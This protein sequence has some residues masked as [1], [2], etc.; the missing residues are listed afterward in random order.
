LNGLFW[1][2]LD[3]ATNGWLSSRVD[4]VV[5][6]SVLSVRGRARTL[7]ADRRRLAIV[8]VVAAFALAG[9][10]LLV[11]SAPARSEPS[12]IPLPFGPG[13]AYEQRGDDPPRRPVPATPLHPRRS[14]TDP[15][16]DTARVVRPYDV[17]SD[18]LASVLLTEAEVAGTAHVQPVGRV[19][20][21]RNVLDIGADPRPCGTSTVAPRR[22]GDDGFAVWHMTGARAGSDT[23]F[24]SSATETVSP[25][26]AHAF[27]RQ[28]AAAV[29]SCHYRTVTQ[30][31]IDG[32]ETVRTSWQD[33]SGYRD[34][35][36]VR[37]ANL[38]FQVATT[39][40]AARHSDYADLLARRLLAKW[41]AVKIR[42]VPSPTPAAARPTAGP[43][44]RPAAPASTDPASGSEPQ[45]TGTPPYPPGCL[46]GM[47]GGANVPIEPVSPLVRPTA[48]APR[49]G[50]G[51]P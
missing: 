45:P 14:P 1:K 12:G 49:V 13:E 24:A 27:L 43:T 10:G 50:P 31:Q 41:A 21:R 5:T 37:D 47:C 15:P 30:G 36:V 25:S 6:R 7:R 29:G 9:C 4:Q 26:E 44:R 18:V 46:P 20:A 33:G 3:S 16:A 32:D 34:L 35:I 40:D 51:P 48:L 11:V 8:G 38:I 42:R 28:V 23:Y 2:V 19:G 17:R 39:Q 22:V